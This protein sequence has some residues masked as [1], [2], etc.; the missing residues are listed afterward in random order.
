MEAY[1]KPWRHIFLIVVVLLT[2]LSLLLSACGPVE[3]SHGSSNNGKD[4]D[5]TKENGNDKDKDKGNGNDKD[6]GGNTDKILI[7]HKTG[8]TKKPYVQISVANDAVKDG[9]AQHAGDLIPAPQAGCP[10]K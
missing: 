4:K 6:K 7:C 8:S 1:M 3:K 5:R 2:I 10:T 9:H